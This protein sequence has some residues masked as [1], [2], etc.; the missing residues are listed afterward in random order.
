MFDRFQSQTNVTAFEIG[1]NIFFK[2]WLIVFLA[3][4]LIYFIDTKITY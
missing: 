4:K 1:V 3:N 2:A